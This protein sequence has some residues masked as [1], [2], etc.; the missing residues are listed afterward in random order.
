MYSEESK[1]NA[2]IRLCNWEQSDDNPVQLP[3]PSIHARPIFAPA[4]RGVAKALPSG[5]Q[6]AV[7]EEPRVLYED[8]DLAVVLKPARWS[9]IPQPKGVNAAWARLKPLARRQ[10]VAELL[11]QEVSPPFQAWLLLHF[12]ADPKYD[13]SRD[14]GSDR[15]LAHRLDVETSGPILCGKTSKGFEHAKKQIV[16]GLLKD[17]V[18]LVHG[19]FFSSV[20]S[21]EH[22]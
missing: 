14:Q 16:S 2:I 13:A 10:Q 11:M 22:P 18:A 4:G 7:R 3:P 9:C 20:A 12:G 21:A 15:G 17:Y 8:D 1:H 5:A 19:T 6:N